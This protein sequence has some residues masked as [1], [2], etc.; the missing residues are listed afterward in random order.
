MSSV[1]RDL[2]CRSHLSKKKKRQ[3]N[4]KENDKATRKAIC[5]ATK[6]KRQV[7]QKKKTAGQAQKK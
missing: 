5:R 3:G 6:T 2:I 7:N 4:Q 1:V